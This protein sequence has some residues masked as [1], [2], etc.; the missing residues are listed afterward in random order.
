MAYDVKIAAS[1]IKD[2]KQI[3][4]HKAGKILLGAM[5]KLSKNPEPCKMLSGKF[6][7][8]RR[9]RVGNFRVIFAIFDAEV[10]ILRIGH[11]KDVYE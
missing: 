2:L 6:K 9:L 11:R 7:G 10:K 8:L 5:E 1:A 4:K 3:D